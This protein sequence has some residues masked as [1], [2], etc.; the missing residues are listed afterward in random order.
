MSFSAENTFQTN[1]LGGEPEHISPFT[2]L[3]AVNEACKTTRRSVRQT[4]RAFSAIALTMAFV[5]FCQDADNVLQFLTATGKRFVITYTVNSA[6]K[7]L[8]DGRYIPLQGLSKS[9]PHLICWHFDQ[10]QRLVVKSTKLKALPKL[11][12]IKSKAQPLSK[13]LGMEQ[14]NAKEPQTLEALQHF[15]SA[16][17]IQKRVIFYIVFKMRPKTYA[18]WWTSLSSQTQSD[19][20]LY[21]EAF[22]KSNFSLAYQF[23]QT[24]KVFQKKNLSN[25]KQK[26]EFERAFQDRIS[27]AP[28][29]FCNSKRTSAH[30]HLCGLSLAHQLN[31]CSEEV[32]FKFSGAIAKTF[33]SLWLHFDDQK[34]VR[35]VTYSDKKNHLSIGLDYDPANTDPEFY[36]D[37]TVFGKKRVK[38][39]QKL[40]N[41]IHQQKRKWTIYKKDLLQSLLNPLEHH[42]QLNMTS[43]WNRCL[44]QLKRAIKKH[45]VF[46][47]CSDD[48][49]LHH[50]KMPLVDATK[51]ANAKSNITIKT[52]GQN[53]ISLLSTA[54]LDI[55]NLSNY[56]VDSLA[57]FDPDLDDTCLWQLSG[58]W[59]TQPV[60]GIQRI[61]LP[62]LRHDATMKRQPLDV[63]EKLN[64]RAL[65]NNGLICS[66]WQQFNQFILQQFDLDLTTSGLYSLSSI[67]FK[68]VW[69][70]YASTAGPLSH[71]I[72]NLTAYNESVLRQWS[73]GGYCY[74]MKGEINEGQAI[75]PD[76]QDSERAKTIVSYDISS[77]Y[78]YCASTMQVPAGFGVTFNK[79]Q[80]CQSVMRHRTFEFQAVMF[81]IFKWTEE[82]K[83]IKTVF[84]NFSH[85]GV[86]S[87]GNFP[88]D[89]VAI[90]KDGT[91][92]MV[93]MDGAFCHG[94]YLNPA[95][96]SL[97]RY[98]NDLSRQ[99][100]EEKTTRRDQC[101]LEWIQRQPSQMYRYRVITDC[102]TPHYSK[103]E[104]SR[105]FKNEPKLFDLV[106]GYDDIANDAENLLE[107]C[108]P[109]MMF[110][111]VVT[112]HTLD[113]YSTNFGPLFTW[114]NQEQQTSC[115]G[116]LLLTSDYYQYLRNHH[117]FEIEAVDWIIFYKKCPHL[118][119][120]FKELIKA[121]T[122]VS[123]PSHAKLFKNIINFCCGYFGLNLNKPAHS[124]TRIVT[125]LPR[126]FNSV[127][128]SIREV[129]YYNEKT[130][131]VLSTSRKVSPVPKM[132]NTPL[133][134]FVNIIEFGKLRLNQILFFFHV[135]FRPRAYK[136]CYINI[137]SIVAVIS[138]DNL[139]QIARA[140]QSETF[141]LL[142]SD[143]FQNNV[144]GSM[145]LEWTIPSQIQWRL[146]SPL[147]RCF[148]IKSDDPNLDMHKISSLKAISSEQAFETT[149]ALLNKESITVSQSRRIDKVL[150]TKTHVIPVTF[151]PK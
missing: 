35:H 36:E 106:Q 15:F 140:P 150:N 26:V 90:M 23:Y 18:L 120:V 77:C 12:K 39:W 99:E 54:E 74:S 149:R 30:I 41:F 138:T 131:Y 107:N 38:Q 114:E 25:Q 96:P 49:V 113:D 61:P 136:I 64:S 6:V 151:H 67:A 137:D 2:F 55:V 16:N 69:L 103:K 84:S 81:T 97:S 133:P 118:S 146:V 73:K 116:T 32:F 94:C 78:G 62:L 127:Q 56:L 86:L 144:P 132:S 65:N 79:K 112:G 48:T 60:G 129:V 121:R 66:L 11:T 13:L 46:V 63:L 109:S 27:F 89:L 28:S 58:E 19:S 1:N 33:G 82:N 20:V 104:L 57:D 101:I 143:I 14:K 10:H 34:F 122:N 50:L 93:Q 134:I 83:Q 123:N 108:P 100:V 125:R 40:F 147:I 135:Y 59:L 44:Q 45:V 124:Q 71:P 80:K 142:F 141:Q 47:Y 130:Y 37:D 9:R 139:F 148:A 7:L 111:A 70:K 75:Y 22:P 52:T 126:K 110:L 5:E 3:D 128:H 102:C 119:L 85:F 42:S 95:C 72:E 98:V 88:I 87:L 76:S 4:L 115:R 29:E 145:K 21:I 117:S 105:S 92:E 24:S 8:M 53:T 17:N 51:S 43:P 68:C 31:I 91:I